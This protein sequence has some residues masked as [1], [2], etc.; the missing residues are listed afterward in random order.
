MEV[1]NI[2]LGAFDGDD[3]TIVFLPQG[4]PL[5]FSPCAKYEI[6]EHIEM[7]QNETAPVI[8]AVETDDGY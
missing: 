4:E 7:P 1:K 8:G 6:I 3:R 5:V 2:M